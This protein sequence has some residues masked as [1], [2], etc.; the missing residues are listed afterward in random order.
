MKRMYAKLKMRDHSISKKK[1]GFKA[2][3]KIYGAHVT[4]FVHKSLD[5]RYK[6][7]WCVSHYATGCLMGENAFST[8]EE[9][10]KEISKLIR[11]RNSRMQFYREIL[12]CKTNYGV[13]NK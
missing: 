4:V 10:I 12:T 6:G 11:R 13:I 3:I 7:K 9:A 5:S 1:F 2:V 8:K